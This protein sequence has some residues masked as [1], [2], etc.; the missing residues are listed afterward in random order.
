MNATIHVSDLCDNLT[1]M[2][3]TWP[4]HGH[5]HVHVHVHVMCNCSLR[6]IHS[7]RQFWYPLGLCTPHPPPL[8]PK[9]ANAL[10]LPLFADHLVGRRRPLSRRLLFLGQ[11]VDVA[12][13]VGV[14][15][16]GQGFPLTSLLALPYRAAVPVAEAEHS[17]DVAWARGSRAGHM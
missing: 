11:K 13:T 12:S 10:V 17:Y 6:A 9:L 3:M 15:I 5:G 8:L 1:H 4:S 2:Y 14:G 7:S 16:V